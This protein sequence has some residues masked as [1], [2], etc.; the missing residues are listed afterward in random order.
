MLWRVMVPAPPCMTS[1]TRGGSARAMK[2]TKTRRGAKLFMA[3]HFD[4]NAFTTETQRTQR[5]LCVS[6]VIF[7]VLLPALA[8]GPDEAW[9]TISTRHFRIH[10][11][12]GDE[13]WARRVAGDI[14]SVR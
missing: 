8:Q 10:F 2:G 12:A 11:P 7:L 4:M 1:M 9:R 3:A 14:E 5:F 6:V 13:A